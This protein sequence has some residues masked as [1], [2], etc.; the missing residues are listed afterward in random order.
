MRWLI[1]LLLPLSSLQAIGRSPWI[2]PPFELDGRLRYTFEHY[3]EIE[4]TPHSIHHPATN[5]YLNLA[6]LFAP[7][8]SIDLEAELQIAYTRDHH[9]FFEYGEVTGRILWLDD[10]A[11]D[12]I[13][14]MTTL[15]LGGATHT[16]V[17]D[18]S[19]PDIGTFQAKFG[20]EMGKEW[21][22]SDD[23]VWRNWICGAIGVANKGAPWLLGRIATERHFCRW[24]TLWLSLHGRVGLGERPMPP[25][26]RFNGY[27]PIAYRAAD[28][29]AGYE[30]QLGCRATLSI[31]YLHRIYARNFPDELQQVALQLLLPF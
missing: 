22:R 27:G 14:L 2:G 19:T 28:L 23:W 21:A 25:L 26:D 31:A 29:E 20:V 18:P 9:V 3:R 8:E 24:N 1:A 17:I 11:G 7:W 10:V 15:S 12:P 30:L 16:A 13:S 6:L 5:H 4:T